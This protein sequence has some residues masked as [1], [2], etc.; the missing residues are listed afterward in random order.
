MVLVNK[1]AKRF[2]LNKTLQALG[3]SKG[4]WHYRCQR[5]V[6]YTEKYGILRNPL[7]KLAKQHPYYGYRKATEELR[8]QGY[9]VNHKVVQKLQKAWELPLLRAVRH[10]QASAIRQA[11]MTMGER[12]NLVRNLK[13]IHPLELLYLNF[14]RDLFFRPDLFDF[15]VSMSSCTCRSIIPCK[16]FFARSIS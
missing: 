10:P 5:K 15:S 9:E 7:M 1:C 8:A 16:K 12:V 11:L 2:G 6:A 4:T 3:I 14:A 13:H